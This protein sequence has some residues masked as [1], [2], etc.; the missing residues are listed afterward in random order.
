M[1]ISAYK[2][3]K[4]IFDFVIDIYLHLKVKFSDNVF[5]NEILCSLTDMVMLVR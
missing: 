2:P 3:Y 1:T 4:E 5:P